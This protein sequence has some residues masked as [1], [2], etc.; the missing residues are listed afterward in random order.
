MMNSDRKLSV[1]NNEPNSESRRQRSSSLV[2]HEGP[3]QSLEDIQEG[4]GPID[5][6]HSGDKN[7]LFHTSNN[8]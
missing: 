8:M 3:I 1:M 6:F 5:M 4:D 2:G 7:N